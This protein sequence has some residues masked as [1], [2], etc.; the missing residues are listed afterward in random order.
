[1]EDD[2]D[3]QIKESNCTSFNCNGTTKPDPSDA[4][5]MLNFFFKL[6]NENVVNSDELIA[7]FISRPPPKKFRKKSAS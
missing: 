7:F 1:M 3:P 4:Y 2:H 6:S 5:F